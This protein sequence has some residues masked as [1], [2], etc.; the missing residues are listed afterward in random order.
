MYSVLIVEDEKLVRFGLKNSIDWAKFNME[1]IGDEADGCAALKVYQQKKP[2]IIITDLK[3]PVMGGMELISKIREQNEKTRIIILSCMEEF[4]LTRKAMNFD[5]SGYILKLTM[6][7]EEVDA[8]LKKVQHELHIQQNTY[9][10][11]QTIKSSMDMIKDKVFKDFIFYKIISEIEFIKKIKE[12]KLRIKPGRYSMCVMEIDHFE[13]LKRLFKDENGQLMKFAMLNIIN[14]ILDSS[15]NGEVFNY[16]DVKYGFVF[17]L[18]DEA[19]ENKQY[20]EIFPI[21]DRIRRSVEK[22]FNISVSFGI[23]EMKAKYG[24]MKILFEQGDKALENKFLN[25]SGIYFISDNFNMENY[26]TDKSAIL[27]SLL[28]FNKMPDDDFI[29]KYKLKIV[30]ILQALND[31]KAQVKQRFCGLIHWVLVE[32]H[33]PNN[34]FADY[35]VSFS[36]SVQESETLDEIIEVLRDFFNTLN[37]SIKRKRVS[38]NDVLKAMEYIEA[39]YE[40]DISLQQVADKVN[41]SVSYL[42]I[43]IKKE[44]EISYTEYLN[45]FRIEKAKELLLNTY[46]K[47]YEIAEMIGFNDNTYF[48]KAFKRYTG[49]NPREFRKLWV[50]D[51]EDAND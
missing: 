9:I 11:S 24:L 6:T 31:T 2:D 40:K 50:K 30:S 46:L 38:N 49:K 14:E 20:G 16:T 3:M 19:S 41:L 51:W 34:I 47:S 48:S 8:V 42:S 45:E 15:G 43:L 37:A 29:K 26:F 27:Y 4:E 7:D 22:F 23:S 12:L 17:S 39:N 36:K 35:S 18:K 21:L 33:I 25:G 13:K 10:E 44:L 32:F 5:V 1:V 28:E